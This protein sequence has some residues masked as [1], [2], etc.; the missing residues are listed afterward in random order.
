M[1]DLPRTVRWAV[2]AYRAATV[3]LP[4]ERRAAYGEELVDC[5]VR[6]AA[7]ARRRSRLALVRVTLRSLAD[8][9]LRVPREHRAA[10]RGATGG[11]GGLQGAW[12]D[13]RHAARR[14]RR[15][16]S[17]TATSVL[18]LALGI[19]ATTSVFSLV[20]GVVLSPLPYPR[21]DRLVLLDHS[22]AGIGVDRGLG[23]TYGFYRFYAAHARAAESM[24]MYAWRDLTLTGAG[25]PVRSTGVRTTPSLGK[26]LRITPAL[27]RWLRDDDA[28]PGAAP[29][30]VLSNRLWRD[31]F[32][33][34]PDV[35]G[36]SVDLDGV[37][38][39]IVGVAAPG[40]A[41]PS[42]EASLWTP[43]PVPA[44]GVGGWNEK[45]VARLAP[46]ATAA[47]LE[48][49]L[50][51]WLPTLRATT[52]DPAR[53]ASYLD[54]AG[55]RPRVVDLKESVVGD[56]RPTL[57]I[58]MGTVGFVLLVALANVA[59]LFLVRAEEGQRERWLQAALGAGRARLLRG[60]LAES[61]MVAGGAGLL[62]VA[63]AWGAV[64]AVKERAPVNIPRLAEVGL[65]PTV[66]AVAGAA[67]VAT[68]GLLTGAGAEG[69]IAGGGGLAGSL[70][71]GG[72]PVTAGRGRLRG[73]HVL[74]AT[75]VA[76]ATVLLVGSVLLLR[77]FQRLRSV[78]LGFTER[79]ALTFQVGLP[80]AVYGTREEMV[81]F[82]DELLRR[83]NEI[84]G[85]ASAAAVGS[86]LPLGGSMCW[87][88]TLEAE[89]F[90]TPAGRVAAVTGA[91]L[92]TPGYFAAMG[93]DV[94]G[95][96]FDGAD[97]AGGGRVAVLSR[98]AAEAYFP[99]VDALGRRVRFSQEG[100]W[101]TVVGVASDVRAKVETDEFQ[102]AIYLPLR[103]D[104][105]GPPPSPLAYVLPTSVPPGSVV[106]A[107]RRAVA[108]LD[109]GVPLAD[110]ETLADRIDH[111][112]APTAFAVALVGLA[113]SIALILGL[114]GV[115]GVIA[116]AVSR[117]TAEIGVRM[118]LGAA[119][120]DIRRMVLRQG[121]AFVLA[122]LAL[123]LVAARL[124]GR[125]ME[126]MLFQV[127]P[128]DP[129]SYAAVAVLILASAWAALF[130]PARRASRV[131][132]SS[133]LR[134]D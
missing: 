133:A 96:A 55:I 40:F 14:L 132:P 78:D 33:G 44:T 90:P 98:S 30:V 100:P 48:R 129:A 107:V 92:A 103:P 74:V 11:G 118:A 27:G 13:V 5:F 65:D 85:V 120:G 36:R 73:R 94:R 22:G 125:L 93:I 60:A 126:G 71:E 76:L 77:T 102:R 1:S 113:A 12:Q 121:S 38:H 56:V 70:K 7:D 50:T 18:T 67:V 119:R 16:P 72:A 45:A 34:D 116:Y 41:F 79:Q 58:L 20:H 35:V 108:D 4:R 117:R 123:G 47:D 39:E 29:V 53:V 66:L 115:Y 82:H 49:E 19:A 2:A 84:P 81:Q 15:R 28:A 9:A 87:G 52:D 112:T 69:G 23:V 17:F 111:A 8:L 124:L 63:A 54:D 101:Y 31:R 32:G 127:G 128:G 122:G 59:N 21:S 83:L 57:W 25:D 62:G 110:V 91:R 80:P 99:G 42:E 24:A 89:G 130:L 3:L 75:Q 95:R 134:A 109:P 10:S 6:I 61:L 86:C 68:V 131:E 64:T 106:G 105:D 97:E 88:E 104:V 46:G 51:G 43:L 26:V 114:V 37:P